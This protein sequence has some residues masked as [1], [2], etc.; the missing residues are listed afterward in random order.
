MTTTLV[1]YRWAG[2]LFSLFALGA[3]A[4]AAL[5]ITAQPQ[6]LYANVGSAVTFSVTATATSAITYQW[7]LNGQNIPGANGATL[8]I[9]NVQPYHGGTYSVAVTGD[10]ATLNSVNA[11]LTVFTPPTVTNMP[12]PLTVIVGNNLYIYP[13]VS[14]SSPMTYQWKK[15]GV[16]IAGATSYYYN[17]SNVTL[18]SAG[19]YTL[20][21]TNAAGIITS[22]PTVVTVVDAISITANPTSQT[23]D[24]GTTV[25][26]SVTAVGPGTLQYTW[27]KDGSSVSGATSSVLSLPKVTS[28]QS[29]NYR[30]SIR[31]EY[32]G[33][34][35]DSSIATV[36]I[37][38][39]PVIIDQ[40][41]PSVIAT[42]GNSFSLYVGA[43]GAGPFTYRWY[44]DG[45]ALTSTLRYSNTN[46][47][48]SSLY[49]NGTLLSDAGTY[50]VV[51]SNAYGSV[52]SA[53]SVVAVSANPYGPSITM[54]PASQSTLAGSALTLSVTAIGSTYSANVS[55]QWLKNGSNIV[56]A[57]GANYTI[58]S[59]S[60]SDAG[61]Y[62]VVVTNG[63]SSVTSNIAHVT[64][65]AAASGP[66]ITQHPASQ[67]AAIGDTATLTVAASG[68]P[69]PT[70]QWK[71]DGVSIAGATSATLTLSNVQASDAGSYTAIA[72][73]VAG[74]ATSAPA[75]LT[76]GAKTRVVNLSTRAQVGTGDNVLI[77]GFIINGTTPKKMLIR[78]VGPTLT[79]FSVDGFLANPFLRVTTPSGETV[80]SNDDWGITSN[81]PELIAAQTQTG[82]FPLQKD[83]KD[84][85]LV[86]TLQPGAYTAVISGVNSTVGV[87]LA[88]LYEVDSTTPNQLVNISAR[89]FVGTGSKVLIPGI[90]VSGDAPKKF[91]VRAVG[92]GLKQFGVTGVLDNP[93][94]EVVNSKGDTI[95][96]ND[97]WSVNENLAETK[98]VTQA[99]N[100]FTLDADSKDAA[101]VV[102]L[103]PGMYT[104][105][106]RGVGETSG[107]ALVELYQAP[108]P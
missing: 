108:S 97:D 74:T 26:L 86:A 66:V 46:V 45:T 33:S 58:L 25:N 38:A 89:A 44:K 95:A 101:A 43:A 5:T 47:T 15:D 60:A 20:T 76:V 69:T 92:P 72:S 12:G 19:S 3:W 81:L 31:N 39:S 7:Q 11:L 53:D 83:S 57:T 99:L 93:R 28:A 29:G 63:Y 56:G 24:A 40:P 21:V 41:Q 48:S 65:G 17:S 51:I 80:A 105:V 34:T 77:A 79:Q 104:V 4:Q 54:Q 70:Y 18:A 9:T 71:K 37:K 36:V 96:V 2:W 90:V 32:Q 8:S 16:A 10:G 84:A 78:A 49:I 14:G 22:N 98:S 62:S 27:Y 13:N 88:E 106:V 55:Y 85:A 87:A 52:T 61:D 68:N 30:V 73:N 94:L 103:A 1:R 23:V 64:V 42:M 50:S 82:A 91:L 75:A 59:V 100:I 102:S 35:V 6:S 107:I 67:Y